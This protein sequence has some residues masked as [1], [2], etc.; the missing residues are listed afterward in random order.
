MSK[1][2]LMMMTQLDYAI[3]GNKNSSSDCGLYSLLNCVI[4][5][6]YTKENHHPLCLPICSM[7]LLFIILFKKKASRGRATQIHEQVLQ[8][9]LSYN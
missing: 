1:V 9:K 8:H 4:N 2:C 5:I 6:G 3:T 7:G